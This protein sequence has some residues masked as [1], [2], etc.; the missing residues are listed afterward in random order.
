MA[1]RMPGV[2]LR[3]MRHAAMIVVAF[4]R[5]VRACPDVTWAALTDPELAERWIGSLRHN[6]PRRADTT[7][8]L[9]LTFE[10]GRPAVPIDV[11]AIDPGRYA[12]LEVGRGPERR[13]ITIYLDTDR[14][15][16]P[17]TTTVTVMQTFT[18]AAQLERH[19]PMW[20]WYLDRFA[21]ALEGGDP[22]DLP[23][24]PHYVPGRIPHYENLVRQAIREGQQP[25]LSD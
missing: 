16:T 6:P 23:L 10:A 3:S 13:V 15:T 24:R 12:V 17:R 11:L 20:D 8:A 7:F 19:G 1:E 5:T 4:D 14:H 22:Q 2:D 9:T 18:D 25:D 21:L